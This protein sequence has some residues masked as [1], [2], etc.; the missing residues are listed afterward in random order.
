MDGA[1]GIIR[2]VKPLDRELV[3][4]YDLMVLATDQG[5]PELTGRTNVTITILDI[6][7]N[8]DII[9]F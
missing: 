3:S 6:N 2:T 1:S 5:S 4:R 9:A 8:L 7:G